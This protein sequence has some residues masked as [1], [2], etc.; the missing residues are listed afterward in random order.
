MGVNFR[1]AGLAVLYGQLDPLQVAPGRVH[2]VSHTLVTPMT[3]YLCS[4]NFNINRVLIECFVS[5]S[6]P[7][8]FSNL[9]YVTLCGEGVRADVTGYQCCI[10]ASLGGTFSPPLPP[11]V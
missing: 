4:F 3:V 8:P 5:L 11:T 9:I 6:G 7:E 10:H 1:Q 2:C